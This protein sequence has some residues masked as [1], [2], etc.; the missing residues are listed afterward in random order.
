VE[1]DLSAGVGDPYVVDSLERLCLGVPVASMA[2]GKTA[3]RAPAKKEPASKKSKAI[4]KR[5]KP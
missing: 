4:D 3:K 1:F 5:S 2:K